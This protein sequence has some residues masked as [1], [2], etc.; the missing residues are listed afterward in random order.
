MNVDL[1]SY[2]INQKSKTNSMKKG[3]PICLKKIGIL[4]FLKYVTISTLL[5]M[6]A[7]FKISFCCCSFCSLVI[8]GQAKIMRAI[9]IECVRL[10]WFESLR[11]CS[12]VHCVKLFKINK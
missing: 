12:H 7:K 6:G 3:E 1:F 10:A 4:L 8:Y 9:C 5:N 2:K 11:K